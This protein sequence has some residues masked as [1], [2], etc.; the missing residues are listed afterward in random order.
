MKTNLDYYLDYINNFLTIEVFADY[1]HLDVTEALNIVNKG[2]DDKLALDKAIDNEYIDSQFDRSKRDHT[3]NNYSMFK[4]KVKFHFI[5][6]QAT[7]WLSVD[8]IQLEKIR[9]ILKGEL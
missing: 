1:Y 3:D 6:D 4:H 7:N 2:R 8:N 5:N 9:Q